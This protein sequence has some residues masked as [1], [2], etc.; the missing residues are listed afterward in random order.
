MVL[1]LMAAAIGANEE[2]TLT[3]GAAL[4]LVL[5]LLLLLT[6]LPQSI[7]NGVAYT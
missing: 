4:P 3:S 6:P 1:L 2:G 5:L 7:R